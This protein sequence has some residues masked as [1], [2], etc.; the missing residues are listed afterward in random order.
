MTAGF[1][2]QLEA[3]NSATRHGKLFADMEDMLTPSELQAALPELLAGSQRTRALV[4]NSWICHI[5]ASEIAET[6]RLTLLAEEIRLF[7]DPAVPVADKSLLIGFCGAANRL[8]VPSSMFLQFVPA[9]RF[10]VLIVSDR[11]NSSFETG[12]GGSPMWFV[13]LMRRLAS[14]SG[15]DRYRG[16][17]CVGASMGG[18]P[19][20]RAG[21][22]LGA[23]RSV[24][25]GGTFAWTINKL[26]GK[27]L[28]PPAFDP[29]C[30]CAAPSNGELV[31]AHTRFWR[32]IRAAR[33]LASILRAR[34]LSLTRSKNHNL[35]YQLMLR[36]GLGAFF[37]EM[38]DFEPGLVNRRRP[39][40]LSARIDWLM[41]RLDLRIRQ[42][43]KL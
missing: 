19:A 36:G 22:V 12:I 41:W 17:Y 3:A 25:M 27:G 4:R 21:R 42:L 37:A 34:D 20:L 15:A 40:S 43:L 18:F 9:S 26:R 1:P 13:E 10:D 30:A 16:I 8:M 2:A 14:L 33:H 7:Q 5:L 31:A 23:R 24:S 29:L 35:P 28:A 11:S 32:D 39:L 6:Y 38:F